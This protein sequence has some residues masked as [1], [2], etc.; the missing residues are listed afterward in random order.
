MPKSRIAI[1]LFNDSIVELN[2]EELITGKNLSKTNFTGNI[3]NETLLYQ[4]KSELSVPS[5]VD[6]VKKFGEFEYEDLKTASSGAILFIKINGRILG[7]CFGTSVANINRNNIE[8]DFGLGVAFQN[9]L[10]NQTKSIESFTLA[11]NPLTNNRN[12]TVPTSK[13]NFNIDTYLENITELSGY[14]YRNGKRTLIKGKEFYSMP[15]P[16]TIEEIVEVCVDVV[17]KYN[18]S[19]NDENF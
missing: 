12:S 6:I 2:P 9:M 5:W 11:H 16:N 13:Q 19:I 8:T 7:C 10:S 14:F 18:L 17:S 15:C 1:C 3:A 4:R